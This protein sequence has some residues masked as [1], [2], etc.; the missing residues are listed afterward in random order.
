MDISHLIDSLND[1][2][3]QAVTSDSSRLLVLAGAGSGKTR[4]LVHRIA[5]MV[6]VERVSPFSILAVTFTNKAAAEMRQRVESLLKAPTSGM[7]IGTFHSLA[8]RL[9]RRHWQ[10][11]K[12]PEN[13]QIMDADDQLRVIKRVMAAMN[14]DTEKWPP[15]QAQ[16]F[17]N[18]NKDEGR[19][20]R[21]LNAY[22]DYSKQTL[23]EVYQ[24]YEQQC[25]QSGLID[26]AELLLRAHEL[27][28]DNE[29]I[30]N[31]YRDK[32][33]HILV[34]EFQD[35]NT[36]QYAWLRLLLSKENKIT[37]VGDD[38]Q[39]IYGWRGAKVENIRQFRQQF[40]DGELIRLEQNYRS[41]SVLL[42]AANRVIAKNSD[43]L[44]KELW[45]E[46]EQ[47]EPISL[48][49]AYNEID[50]ARFIAER[51]QQHADEYERRDMAILYRSN[52]QSRVLEEAL[53]RAN[54]PYRIYG[55]LRFFDRAEI[56]NALAYLRLIA[57]RGDDAAFERVVNVPPRGI[58]DRTVDIIR[59]LAREKGCSAWSAA[60]MA[61][62]YGILKARAKSS[63][64]NFLLLIQNLDAQSQNL[65]LSE[66]VDDVIKQSTLLPHYE[67]EKGERAA[68]RVENLN[69]LITAAQQFEQEREE[70][71]DLRAFL[72]H[73]ALESGDAQTDV[74]ENSVQMMTLH[75]AKGLEFP[76]VFM[77]G[78]E[79]GL[80]PHSLSADDPDQLEE[81]RR[82]CYVGITRAMKKLYMT[83]A[84]QRRQFGKDKIQRVS[85]FIRDLPH[86]CVEEIRLHSE[87][88]RP[89][90]LAAPA[91][92]P[93]WMV[94]E[95][96]AFPLGATVQHQ[97]FGMGTV[98][99]CEGKGR[100]A[101]VQVNFEREG[102]KWLM[103]QYANLEQ[104]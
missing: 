11:A 60:E 15:K 83:Y 32:F 71:A 45:T 93:K 4:V 48:Y 99:A 37:L 72:D 23:I 63:V 35:T 86:D 87:Y 16:W 64:E 96:A 41:T 8:H 43:R 21:N 19:R 1:A 12:I 104:V 39:S 75:S 42:K 58:G 80:F 95:D 101:R 98:L 50:E 79:Q 40:P 51:I 31:H 56:K 77:S 65:P 70:D 38:D 34:D 9:L 69:E 85:N 7:W 24:A 66:Q 18:H 84:E 26:F 47:G 54:I 36:I 59:Q 17:I 89:T 46:G 27:L 97:K 2:Q 55:G 53:I 20:S 10:Q 5:W 44:G 22:Q 52:A 49:A 13:F 91:E 3:R 67:S 57:Y 61:V 76:L 25:E 90:S 62:E 82:L 73:A 28:R 100:Q 68:A 33:R 29:E 6:E 88:G 94:D 103:V 14:L 81:E 30:L 74:E 102:C 92:Q 78:M